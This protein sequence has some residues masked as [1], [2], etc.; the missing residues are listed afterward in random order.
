M[1]YRLDTSKNTTTLTPIPLNLETDSKKPVSIS[2]YLKEN[3]PGKTAGELSDIMSTKIKFTCDISADN[4]TKIF[5]ILG[6]LYYSVPQD[7]PVC[8][9]QG[10]NFTITKSGRQYLSGDKI[11]AMISFSGYD[12]G[13]SE[14]YKIQ[15][16]IIREF[17]LEKLKSSYVNGS[18]FK[19]LFNYVSTNFTINDLLKRADAICAFSGKNH[20]KIQSPENA[21]STDENG[22]C[23]LKNAQ[24]CN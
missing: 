10:N 19:T 11:Y 13:N 1:L 12:G 3:G 5:D 18:S 17:V 21:Y 7:I 6:G 8:S 16:N 2:E 4:F 23:K 24:K 15:S 20:I 22:L 9:T 14:K